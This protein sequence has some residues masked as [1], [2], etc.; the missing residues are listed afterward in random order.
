MLRSLPGVGVGVAGVLLAEAAPALL[1]GDYHALRAHGGTAPVTKQ[2]GRQ[3][4][5]VMRRACNPRLRTA[6][7]HWARV[8]VQH[9]EATHTYYA[10]L[11]ARGHSHAR[12]LRS[13][14]DRWLRILSAMVI[15]GTPY[16][17]TRFVSFPVTS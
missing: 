8:S 6:L 1:A 10:R 15:S 3:R 9:D 16:D 12:T 7:F 2:S 5:V 14:A 13:V 17:P 11:R 4:L